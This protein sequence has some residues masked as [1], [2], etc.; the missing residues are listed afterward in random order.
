M[1]ATQTKRLHFLHGVRRVVRFSWGGTLSKPGMSVLMTHNNDFGLGLR[2][3]ESGD[4]KLEY[5]YNDDKLD[6]VV[7]L[8]KDPATGVSQCLFHLE[9]MSEEHWYAG[10]YLPGQEK[11]EH[12]IIPSKHALQMW[13]SRLNAANDYGDVDL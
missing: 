5:R 6:E 1:E 4:F 7:M 11:N 3:H 10:V 13:F 2:I 9:A 8:W 12:G